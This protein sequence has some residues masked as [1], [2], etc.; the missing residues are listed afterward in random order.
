M[1]TVAEHQHRFRRDDCT[2]VE[3][4]CVFCGEIHARRSFACTVPGCMFQVSLPL[5][6]PREA[7]DAV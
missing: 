4:I 5:P 6:L 2:L 1:S 7:A 3:M